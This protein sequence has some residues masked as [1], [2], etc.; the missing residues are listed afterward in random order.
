MNM[1]RRINAAGLA[2]VKQWEGL[3]TKAYRDVADV[4]TIGY[5]HTSA[6]GAPVVTLNMVI[7]E[8]EAGAILLADLAKFEERVSRLV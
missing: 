1:N 2:L 5:W 3:K 6:A 4:L 8:A 7:T